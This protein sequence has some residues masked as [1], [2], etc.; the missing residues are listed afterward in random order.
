MRSDDV[1]L[2]ISRNLI[3]LDEESDDVIDMLSSLPARW[4]HMI[5]S[6]DILQ[7]TVTR[8]SID[9]IGKLQKVHVPTGRTV[10]TK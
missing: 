10:N 6:N 9:V 4:T 3:D 5:K 2:Q 7:L 1:L 8:S